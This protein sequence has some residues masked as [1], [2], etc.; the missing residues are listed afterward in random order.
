[1]L[2][3]VLII[4]LVFILVSNLLYAFVTE[5]D[6]NKK[7]VKGNPGVPQFCGVFCHQ[8]ASYPTHWAAS[9][10]IESKD[11]LLNIPSDL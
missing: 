2:V 7:W 9:Y 6:F 3:I 8:V 10:T 5:S 11:R 1:M 4:L